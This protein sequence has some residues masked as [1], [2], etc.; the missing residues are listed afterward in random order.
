[1][2][3]P[4][5][6]ECLPWEVVA[7]WALLA[8]DLLAVVWTYAEVDPDQLYH[9]SE[10]GLRGG[11]SRVLVLVNFPIALIAVALALIALDALP[12]RAWLVGTAALGACAVTAWPGVVD[13][14]DLTA[15]WVN[16]IPALGV[17]AAAWLA[18]AARRHPRI[19]TPRLPLDR[20]RFVLAIVATALSIPWLLAEVGRSLPDG[21]YLMRRLGTEPDGSVIPAVHLGHHHGLDGLLTLLSALALSRI[22]LRSRRITA[23]LH[24]YLGLALAYGTINLANDAWH[25]QLVKRGWLDWSIPSALEPRLSWVWLVVLAAALGFAV[26]LRAEANAQP[27]YS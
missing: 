20:A 11:L 16:A 3:R 23:V 7:V 19:A 2:T 26:L 12:R 25:E 18:V 6:L 17:G 4:R 27:D 21:I 1:M 5:R 15:K 9:V 13:Q 24:G 8:T 14:A 22:R 10:T